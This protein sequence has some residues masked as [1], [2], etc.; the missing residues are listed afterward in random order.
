M[1][2]TILVSLAG[3]LA[4]AG[5]NKA[6]TDD[7]AAVDTAAPVATDTTAAAMPDTS[8]PQGFVD[9]AASSDMYEIEAAKV[10]Q[11]MGKSDK[12]KAFAAMMIKDHGTSTDKLKAAV[13][14]AGAG[15]TMPTAMQAK[16]QQMLDGLK[17]AGDS[18]DKMYAEQQVAA[19]DEAMRLMQAQA[20]SGT[21]APLKMF[22]SDVLP[23]I[24]HHAG[25]ASRLP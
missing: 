10:A 8:T 1:K 21:S 13:A 11:Q 14:K 5:C 18:F 16:H 23:V 2:T 12:L 20:D 4:L 24:K 22:A 17:N 9:M 15:V 25:D 6:S 3:A 7:T 19:H